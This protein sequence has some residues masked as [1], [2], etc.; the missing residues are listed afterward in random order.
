MPSA[1][2]Y[3]LEKVKKN[4]DDSESTKTDKSDRKTKDIKLSK[5]IEETPKGDL[6]SSLSISSTKSRSKSKADIKL[7]EDKMQ[8]NIEKMKEEDMKELLSMYDDIDSQ[9]KSYSEL[10]REK[11]LVIKELRSR[12]KTFEKMA[13]GYLNKIS[14]N[15]VNVGSKSFRKVEVEKQNKH[16]TLEN[17][18]K[19]F[20]TILR[21]NNLCEDKKQ[22]G[23]LVIEFIKLLNKNKEVQKVTVFQKMNDKEIAKINKLA[24]SES[25]SSEEESDSNESD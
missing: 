18:S 24:F 1:P 5:K 11:S 20:K 2:T 14:Q 19:S 12:K 4:R 15:E 8:E 23:L 13:L 6:I 7:E 22:I 3:K 10:S 17:A 9:L 25:E 21:D 16:I